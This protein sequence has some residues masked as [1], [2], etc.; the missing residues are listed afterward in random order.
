[1]A[2]REACCSERTAGET[3]DG[4]AVGHIPAGH[5]GSLGREDGVK[6][7][8]EQTRQELIFGSGGEFCN[9]KKFSGYEYWECKE[10]VHARQPN[11]FKARVC[12]TLSERRR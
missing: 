3:Y 1:M 8:V 2:G 4:S 6:N 12:E 5:K 11:D 7:W 9:L 10:R